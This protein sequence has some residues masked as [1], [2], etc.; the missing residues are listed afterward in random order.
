MQYYTIYLAKKKMLYTLFSCKR[1]IVASLRVQRKICRYGNGPA[2]KTPP[3]VRRKPPST[4]QRI[5]AHQIPSASSLGFLPLDASR[6]SARRSES[7]ER[8]ARSR[9]DPR[10]VHAGRVRRHTVNVKDSSA[11]L[12]PLH[13]P[14]GRILTREFLCPCFL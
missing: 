3:R 7:C 6:A 13:V 8:V 11:L 12:R 14:S 2:P 1:N 9:R 5:T 4:T 10:P